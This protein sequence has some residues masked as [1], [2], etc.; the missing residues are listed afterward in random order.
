[1]VIGEK[2][3]PELIETKKL[4]FIT[5]RNRMM[6]L[7]VDKIERVV[8]AQS[9]QIRPLPRIFGVKAA[10]WFPKVFWYEDRPVLMLNPEAGYSDKTP[11]PDEVEE[12]LHHIV[13]E[14]TIADMMMKSL[15]N[16]LKASAQ[17]GAERI[18]HIL[19]GHARQ[20]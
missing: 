15:D 18:R 3:S 12:M 6:A 16:A 4:M 14:D 10:E 1:M 2:D 13:R 19:E 17:R 5:V 9:G 20:I 11:I 7:M 8:P